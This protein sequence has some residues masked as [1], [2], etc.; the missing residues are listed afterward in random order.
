MVYQWFIN[1]KSQIINANC[2]LFLLWHAAVVDRYIHFL[3]IILAKQHRSTAAP[4][5]RNKPA[6]QRCSKKI[7]LAAYYFYFFLQKATRIPK[8]KANFYSNKISFWLTFVLYCYLLDT[9]VTLVT[10]HS[11]SYVFNLLLHCWPINCDF[12]VRNKILKIWIN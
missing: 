3:T 1:Q 8:N 12:I 5:H 10:R 11:P 4:Q 2:C 9:E 7:F 6:P